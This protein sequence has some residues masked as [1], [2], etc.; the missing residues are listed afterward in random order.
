MTS[1]GLRKVWLAIGAVLVVAVVFLSLTPNPL[2]VGQIHKVKIGHV[3]A[4]GTLMLWFAQI[5]RSAQGRMSV[6]LVLALMGVVLEFLQ[7]VTGYRSFAYA[8]MRDN[9]LG[10]LA[11]LILACTG[12]GGVLG[13]VDGWLT[14]Y[15]TQAR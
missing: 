14:T 3:L 10:V 9:A 15:N 11:G 6:G 4:Y 13:R 8:D 12:L 2:D 5:F 7:G 1:L